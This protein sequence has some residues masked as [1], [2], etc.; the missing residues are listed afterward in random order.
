M[1]CEVSSQMPQLRAHTHSRRTN[2]A[3][4]GNYRKNSLNGVSERENPASRMKRHSKEKAEGWMDGSDARTIYH[5]RRMFRKASPLLTTLW[6]KKRR[7]SI[8]LSWKAVWA[9]NIFS[10]ME[11]GWLSHIQFFV[12]IRYFVLLYRSDKHCKYTQAHKLDAWCPMHVMHVSSH[13]TTVWVSSSVGG[14]HSMQVFL[15]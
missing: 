8:N 14:M 15:Y 5:G 13:T 9:A 1:G 2:T 4:L 10:W 7:R 6:G 12:H 3:Y 11:P